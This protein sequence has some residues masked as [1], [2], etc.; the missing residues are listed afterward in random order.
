MKKF[1]ETLD[2]T[3][4]VLKIQCLESMKGLIFKMYGKRRSL[5]CIL[6]ALALGISVLGCANTDLKQDSSN[7]VASQTAS[8]SDDSKTNRA[9]NAEITAIKEKVKVDAYGLVYYD[10]DGSNTIDAYDINGNTY[11]LLDNVARMLHTELTY[12]DTNHTITA[13]D[14]TRA[15]A[16]FYM[17]DLSAYPV[18]D[19][20]DDAPDVRWTSDDV[21]DFTFVAKGVPFRTVTK[22]MDKKLKSDGFTAATEKQYTEL[23]DSLSEFKQGECKNTYIKYGSNKEEYAAQM[24]DG[25]LDKNKNPIIII[26]MKGIRTKDDFVKIQNDAAVSVSGASQNDAADSA[27]I[28]AVKTEV[29]VKYYDLKT[30]VD[31][32]KING[33]LYLNLSDVSCLF[34]TRIRYDQANHEILLGDEPRA[35]AVRPMQTIDLEEYPNPEDMVGPP[36]DEVWSEDNLAAN[37]K[38][39]VKDG[40]YQ[41]IRKKIEDKL[42]AE[43][44]TI[45]TEKQF[46][47]IPNTSYTLAFQQGKIGNTYVKTSR[48]QYSNGELSSDTYQSAVQLIDG[49]LDENK[50]PIITVKMLSGPYER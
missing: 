36:P 26:K 31:T 46:N 20:T 7:T 32:C 4:H 3:I 18:P 21:T 6:L 39:V 44:F 15:S 42:K 8:V 25:G 16:A 5:F 45:A 43:G 48:I 22:E 37:F 24:I 49:G 10:A 11:L 34:Q 40:S 29:T 38:F 35:D 19:N 28:T 47:E 9:E 30:K 1:C 33:N 23:T 27:G 50:H 17:P 41:D 14:A 12:D 2:F 13:G